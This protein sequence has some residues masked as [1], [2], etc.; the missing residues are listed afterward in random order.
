MKSLILLIIIIPLVEIFIMIKVGHIV[1]AFNTILLIAFTAFA[2]IYY[3]RLEGLNTLKSGLNQLVKNEIPA[4]EL[5][6][7]A[8][9]AIGALL[10]IFPG[11]L[12]DLIGFI[13]IV[14][15]TRKLLFSATAS[16][17]EKKNFTSDYI[18]GESND[19]DEDK[20]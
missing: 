4:Y 6:S 11:F 12:T 16:K 8:T 13:L 18:E 17:F 7:G 5:M 20:K 2:G 14:P 3:A 10:L 1:G 9:I 19:I 15:F